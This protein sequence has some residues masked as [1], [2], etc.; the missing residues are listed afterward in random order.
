ML[1]DRRTDKILEELGLEKHK[2]VQ[3]AAARDRCLGCI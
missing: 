1:V 3:L 2:V